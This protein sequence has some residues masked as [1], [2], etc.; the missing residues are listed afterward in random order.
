LTQE[1]LIIKAVSGFY[2]VRCGAETIVCRAR[3]RF[4]LDGAEPLVGDHVRIEMQADKTGLVLEVLP[5]RCFFG[6][7]AVANMDSI[8]MVVSAAIPIADPY[9]ADRITVRC[10]KSGCGVVIVINKLDLDPGDSLFAIYQTTGYPTV[11]TSTVTGSGIEELRQIISGKVCCFTGNSGVGKSSI[12]NALDSSFSVQ[13]GEVS[14]RLGRGRHTTRHVE[15]FDLG[16]G[17]YIVDTPGFSAFDN[18]TDKP[19]LCGELAGLFPEFAPFLGHCR[20]D[21][22][23]HMSEP[24]CA[25]RRAVSSGAIHPSRYESYRKMYAEAELI[26]DWK[27]K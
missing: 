1:G 18:E 26:K 7:P 24:D 11:R 27:L 17:T 21:D 20:F 5:R 12:L 6:R 10:E 25:V 13:T 15:L 3:G 16:K 23:A 4:R 8:V 14:Q 2:T 9:L 19:I 22:C